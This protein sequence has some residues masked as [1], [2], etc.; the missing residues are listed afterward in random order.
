MKVKLC[1]FLKKTRTTIPKMSQRKLSILSGLSN[2]AISKYETGKLKP[3]P[4]ALRVISPYLKTDYKYLLWLGGYISDAD[5]E[6]LKS[7]KGEN[8]PSVVAEG[9]TFYFKNNYLSEEEM[10]LIKKYRSIPDEAK[11]IIIR[12]LD[13]AVKV[14]GNDKLIK[15]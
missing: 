12:Q 6:C 4:D 7:G 9:S 2:A 11:D 5:W 15:G 13:F 8:G 14:S 10:E 1:D 3:S